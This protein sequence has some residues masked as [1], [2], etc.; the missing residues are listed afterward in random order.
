MDKALTKLRSKGLFDG[1]QGEVGAY[2][3][4]IGSVKTLRSD[5]FSHLW[6]FEETEGNRLF[7]VAGVDDAQSGCKHTQL[8]RFGNAG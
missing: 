5:D 1:D 6:L 3:H 7:D 2:D 4:L 8:Y